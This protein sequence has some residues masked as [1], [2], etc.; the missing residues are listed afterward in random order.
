MGIGMRMLREWVCDKIYVYVYGYCVYDIQVVPITEHVYACRSGS[1]ADTQAVTDY[2]KY[3]INQH[4]Y[5]YVSIY[6]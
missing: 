6:T 5:V 3:Y 4:R 2:V 1:A